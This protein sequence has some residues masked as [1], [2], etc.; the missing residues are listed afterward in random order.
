MAKTKKQAG[1]GFITDMDRYLF[2]NGTHYE[3]FNKLG[4]HPKTYKGKKGMYF[5][6]WAPHAKAVSLVCDR[7]NWMPGADPMTMLETSGIWEIFIPKMGLGEL[8]KFAITTAV[9]YTHLDVYK[10]QTTYWKQLGQ[11][12]AFFIPSALSCFILGPFFHYWD[13]TLPT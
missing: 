12:I 1:T 4:A 13:K 3:L 11:K 2:G 6:V 7:N 8:Y 5:A 9:S 10:R